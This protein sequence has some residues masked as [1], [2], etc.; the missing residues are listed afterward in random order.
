MKQKQLQE[1]ILAAMM[2]ALAIVLP[3]LTGSIQA[4]GQAFLPMHL[5]V[6]ICGFICGYRYGGLVGFTAPLLRALIVGMPPLYPVALAMSFELAT[7]GIV[8]GLL[9]LSL[10]KYNLIGIYATLILSMLAGRAVYGVVNTILLGIQST[11]YAFKTFI[12]AAFVSG[13][14]G[15]I[16]QLIVIPF[17]VFSYDQYSK[18]RGPIWS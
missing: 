13:I 2:L 4:L 1:M 16:F 14:P 10:K 9:Y 5:P 12:S 6:I 11:P 8:V 3:F 7:Y 17:I 15:I 18:R